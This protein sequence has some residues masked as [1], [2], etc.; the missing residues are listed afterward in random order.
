MLNRKGI[1]TSLLHLSKDMRNMLTPYFPLLPTPQEMRRWDTDAI[2][3]GIP[4][5]SLMENAARAALDVLLQSVTQEKHIPAHAAYRLPVALFMGNGNNGGDAACLARHLL[6]IGARPCVLHT[7]ALGEYRGVTGQHVRLAKRL[8]VPFVRLP[9]N[10]SHLGQTYDTVRHNIWQ[11]AWASI[12]VDG[13]LGTG[14]DGSLRADYEAYVHFINA[15]TAH[16]FIFSLDVPS[17]CNALTGRA[18]PVAVR[19]H[20]TV[21]FA[22]AKPGL[23]M[24]HAH[25]W[26][27]TVSVRSIGIPRKVQEDVGASFYT[28]T[29]KN[30]YRPAQQVLAL[31]PH[32]QYDSHKNSWG[33]V[34]V[35]GGSKGLTGA[36]HLTALA[37]LR[38]GAG[39]VTAAA[40]EACC[41]EIK[42]GMA[43][44]MTLALEGHNW[45]SH[46][47]KTLVERFQKCH[48]LALG[49]GIGMHAHD[50]VRA[51]LECPQRPPAVIDA[52]ALNILA[53]RQDLLHLVRPDDIL[54]PHPLEAA[55][56]LTTQTQQCSCNAVQADRVEAL[57]ALMDKAPCTW[58]L[59]GAGTL[60]GQ[61]ASPI[62][63][64]PHDIPALAVAGSGDVL[65][66]C[67]AALVARMRQV[68]DTSVNS[69]LCAA[70][71]VIV[72]AHAGMSVQQDFPIRGNGA[73]DVAQ[74]LPSAL[75]TVVDCV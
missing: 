36:A 43:D 26:T 73:S 27:G 70:L 63:I 69:T 14:F 33:H 6:D 56:L 46:I 19:A 74:R 21:C 44:I 29:T 54:T 3:C 20:A 72:H 22:A 71:G 25:E 61:R 64:L 31:L 57:R 13:L 49:P 2:A 35:L 34:L 42:G 52:D 41:A 47:P 55:R 28:L 32:T 18:S 58:V 15:L 40:P 45:P 50:F 60:V 38:T 17:G 23:I 12:V 10:T 37:A 75:Q 9:K 4:E 59:K 65:T 24:P 8:G 16:A 51:V 53:H 7:K 67:T 39:L 68:P 48:A 1:F 11:G 66:G 30:T 62:G 5:F